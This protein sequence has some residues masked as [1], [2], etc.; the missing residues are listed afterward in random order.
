M[1]VEAELKVALPRE[2]AGLAREVLDRLAGAAGRPIRIANV[3]YDTPG[4]DLQHSRSALRLRL[5]GTQWLQT[6]NGV[7]LA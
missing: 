3:Y 4:L 2:Q 6:F 7:R 1:S 5:S